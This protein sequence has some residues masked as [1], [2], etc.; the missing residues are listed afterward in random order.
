M[1]IVLVCFRFICLSM[2][3]LPPTYSHEDGEKQVILRIFMTRFVPAAKTD[4]GTQDTAW[5]DSSL[6]ECFLHHADH[7]RSRHRSFVS[8]N[9]GISPRKCSICSREL[10]PLSH[11]RP[12]LYVRIHKKKCIITDDKYSLR[13]LE[14]ERLERLWLLNG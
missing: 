13:Y 6:I 8:S 7:A 10:S 14:T 1:N 3:E 11:I 5:R 9:I 12:Q 2:R 4:P